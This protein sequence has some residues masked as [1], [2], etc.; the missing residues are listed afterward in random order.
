MPVPPLRNQRFGVALLAIIVS[1]T[2][3]A[4]AAA[5]A[6]ATPRVSTLDSLVAVE[7][8]VRWEPGPPE[9]A[10]AQARRD[11]RPAFL[12]F[13]AD[14][15]VPC[16][17]MDRA[18][19]NDPLLGETAEGVTMIRVDIDR[20]EGK[21]LARRYGIFQ[22]PTLVWVN[23]E[24]TER[25]RWVGPLNLRDTRMN[26]GQAALPSSRRA[27]VEAMRKKSPDDLAVQTG[28]LLYYGYRGEVERVRSLAGDLGKRW[29]KRPASDRAAVLLSLGK[30]E[31][32]AGR[33][34]RGL[35]AYRAAADL[36]PE[37]IWA[38]RA[39]LGVSTCQEA[40]RDQ[41]AA[42]AAAWRASDFGPKLPFLAARAARLGMNAPPMP[43][44][45][46]VDDGSGG[47]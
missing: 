15:C 35:T 19:Y 40:R 6:T 27:D 44:P 8:R 47:Q 7:S 9:S 28:A 38:W 20:P 29:A 37:G 12:D 41:V 23:P 24:G 42:L 4:T 45:P 21:A 43:T 11:S 31:E 22:Y 17:W 32:I 3:A 1:T 33:T 34:E 39:W 2:S 36:D 5:S 13:Y 30:A 10:L 14:W 46:G 16:K 26:L 18:V 25:L